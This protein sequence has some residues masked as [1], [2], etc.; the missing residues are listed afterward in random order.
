LLANELRDPEY[1]MHYFERLRDSGDHSLI[2]LGLN[3]GI[4]INLRSIEGGYFP[5]PI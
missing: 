2:E 5:Y 1:L 4:I 3:E